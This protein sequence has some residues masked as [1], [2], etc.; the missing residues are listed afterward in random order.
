MIEISQRFDLENDL[1]KQIKQLEEVGLW[2]FGNR[3]VN[4]KNNWITAIVEIY[5]EDNPVIQ[6]V[7]FDKDLVQKNK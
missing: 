5:S 6:K 3:Q 1:T 7:K 2:V 4:E